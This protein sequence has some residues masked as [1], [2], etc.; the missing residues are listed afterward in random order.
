MGR[1]D[2]SCQSLIDPI[3]ELQ[4]AGSNVLLTRVPHGKTHGPMV[5]IKKMLEATTNVIKKQGTQKH[6]ASHHPH[7]CLGRRVQPVP[8]AVSCPFQWATRM[9]QAGNET[10]GAR[11]CHLWALKCTKAR[12][13]RERE[14]D[15]TTSIQPA[16]LMRT[17]LCSCLGHL[18]NGCEAMA[19]SLLV[20]MPY[21]QTH[22]AFSTL[23][24]IGTLSPD[25]TKARAVKNVMKPSSPTA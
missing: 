9:H 5:I 16:W 12:S 17:D 19:N 18:Q 3:K 8:C 23:K 11:T 15:C 14:R 2:C 7:S 10:S 25:G 4:Q 1:N 22:G 6:S 24:Q 21:E 13:L 20:L